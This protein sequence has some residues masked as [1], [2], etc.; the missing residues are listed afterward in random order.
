V[1]LGNSGIYSTCNRGTL[2]ILWWNLKS[3]DT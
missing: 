3:S 1:P 2:K